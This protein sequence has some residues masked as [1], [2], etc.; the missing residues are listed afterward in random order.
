MNGASADP[1]AK[2]SS[3]LSKNSRINKGQ[4]QNRFLDFRNI[5]NSAITSIVLCIKIVVSL[6]FGRSFLQASNKWLRY[7]QTL[8]PGHFYQINA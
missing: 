8:N 3:R 5:K 2:T 6:N 1:C 7:A 4:S